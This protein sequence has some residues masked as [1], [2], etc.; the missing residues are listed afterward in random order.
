MKTRI[1]APGLSA[2]NPNPKH[3]NAIK[4][5]PA[6][7][8]ELNPVTQKGLSPSV[9]APLKTGATVDEI[10]GYL[11][12]GMS[13]EA[14]DKVRETLAG[15]TITPEEFQ[16]CIYALLQ[17]DELQ[18]WTKQI[19]TAY[20]RVADPADD[21]VRSAMLNYYFSINQSKK[22]FLFFPR[23]STKFFDAWTM[24]QVCLDLGRLDEAKKVARYCRGNL[25]SA[26]DDF[27]KASM[28]DAL[29]G[30]H[31]RNNEFDEA[32]N[33]WTDA[34]VEP[35]FHPQRVSGVVK[36]RLMQAL[37][38]AKA[39]LAVAKVMQDQAEIDLQLPGN[40]QAISADAVRE[41]AALQDRIERVIGEL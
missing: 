13:V 16:T 40:S 41:L 1:P 31:L 37:Q 4:A 17:S 18:R 7:Q 29:A 38:A 8:H 23:R 14:L 15:A 28:I 35:A 27:T 30:Y 34:P 39:G 3:R 32:L 33:L 12:L 22:A 36:A 6:S 10:D 25:A 11:E 26:K 24:M 21:R 5:G 9:T 20:R 19:E 2:E